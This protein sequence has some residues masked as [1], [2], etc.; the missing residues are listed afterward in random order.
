MFGIR[1]R[2][3]VAVA[4]AGLVL[5]GCTSTSTN[6]SGAAAPKDG[7]STSIS[8]KKAVPASKAPQG[9][10]TKAASG[11]VKLS[12]IRIDGKLGTPSAAVTITN[13]SSKL[14]NYVVDVSIT[15]ADGKTQLDAAMV[16]AERLAPGQTTKKAASFKTTQK[17]PKGAKLT[18]VG[19]VRLAA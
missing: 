7:T 9:F 15:S 4:A 5:S 3:V 16:S 14:S 17:L 12:A 6:T 10:G 13:H 18:V 1:T 2:L 8:P 11:D 19:I